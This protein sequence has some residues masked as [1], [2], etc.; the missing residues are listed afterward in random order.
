MLKDS[1]IKLESIHQKHQEITHLILIIIVVSKMAIKADIKTTN[2]TPTNHTKGI[3]N[4]TS[5]IVVTHEVMVGKTN[6]IVTT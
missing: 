5:N 2:T 3:A 4:Q 6:V 1:M